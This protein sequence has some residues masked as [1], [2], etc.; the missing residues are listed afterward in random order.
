MPSAIRTSVGKASKRA[1]PMPFA[2]DPWP[3]KR[4]HVVGFALF[5]MRPFAM[6]PFAT[7]RVDLRESLVTRAWGSFPVIRDVQRLPFTVPHDE[8][9]SSDAAPRGAVAHGT[10]Q[11]VRER[12]P[13]G[14]R[15][16][17]LEAHLPSAR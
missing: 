12:P 16:R 1:F 11:P 6:R 8:R 17:P 15:R 5:V 4:Q 7:R 10:E 13:Q 3:G 2:W 14:A 9:T